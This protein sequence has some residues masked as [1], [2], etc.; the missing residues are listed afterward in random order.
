MLDL[1]GSGL[2]HP[3]TV[4]EFD[5]GDA[6]FGLGQMIDGANPGAQRQVGRGEYRAR[7]RR[8]LPAASA[9][10]LQNAG[11]HHVPRHRHNLMKHNGIEESYP[12]FHGRGLCV[13]RKFLFLF[14]KSCQ[15]V[16]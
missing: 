16:L 13:I 12:M 2:G 9:E 1:P 6:M 10:L 3:E 4:A 5:A 8:G 7:D 11:L 14:Q 15:S